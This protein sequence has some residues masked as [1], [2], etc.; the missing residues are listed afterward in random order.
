M[1][2]P[3]Q[4]AAVGNPYLANGQ[5]YANSLAASGVSA[6]DQTA[7][8]QNLSTAKGAVE[9]SLAGSQGDL[10]QL[11]ASVA[12]IVG[13]I[14]I[15]KNPNASVGDYATATAMLSAG[16]SGVIVV[17]LTAAV[18]VGLIA[19]AT[20]LAAVPIVGAIVL[21]LSALFVATEAIAQK[22]DGASAVPI[23]GFSPE[24]QTRFTVGQVIGAMP[25]Y[26]QSG[27]NV[28]LKSLQLASYM[29]AMLG[30]AMDGAGFPYIKPCGG[31]KG[32]F[33][34]NPCL[35]TGTA[36]ILAQGIVSPS[37]QY[38]KSQ[39]LY[40]LLASV[41]LSKQWPTSI[42]PILHTLGST[43][44][45]N[46]DPSTLWALG[47]RGTNIQFAA[48]DIQ[49]GPNGFTTPATQLTMGAD[50]VTSAIPSNEPSDMLVYLACAATLSNIPNVQ[51][52]VGS[53]MAIR[54]AQYAWVYKAAQLAVPDELYAALGMMLDWQSEN[55]FPINQVVTTILT[56]HI[57]L[58]NPSLS[59]W[60]AYYTSGAGG[61][62][63]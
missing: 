54:L 32:S 39:Q 2:L 11:S 6:A 27:L 62:A 57:H 30:N 8:A 44:A 33:Y 5:A 3:V 16:L 28:S 29:S 43:S 12:G 40:N 42:D 7:I 60:V 36:A 52:Y 61:K 58:A 26:Q 50:G 49:N 24:D 41:L 23:P 19:A 35:D 22:L 13:A 18:Q 31:P 9:S 14:N 59:A 47:L 25:K 17:G 46:T 55:S 10:N 15:L 38:G 1:T 56:G 53:I 51:A 37:G 63:P 21:A 48:A 34:Q 4:V 20:A 45:H